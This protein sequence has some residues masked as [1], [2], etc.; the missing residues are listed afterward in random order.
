M[1]EVR[2]SRLFA[3][4]SHHQ[5]TSL[6]FFF[7]DNND[8]VLTFK[9]HLYYYKHIS[10]TTNVSIETT[11]SVVPASL[12]SPFALCLSFCDSVKVN[13]NVRFPCTHSMCPK[14]H[15]HTQNESSKRLKQMTD[16]T[17]EEAIFQGLFN[18]ISHF[19]VCSA[20][21]YVRVRNVVGL[22]LEETE[23]DDSCAKN[24]K[25][26]DMFVICRRKHLY[27]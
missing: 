5:Y 9:H 4:I 20:A 13:A 7:R 19:H 6:S 3:D 2:A 25:I 1:P 21:F 23:R 11:K 16:C 26:K 15:I 24:L 27:F 22:R 17:G 8:T 12:L 10:L 18:L 14:L